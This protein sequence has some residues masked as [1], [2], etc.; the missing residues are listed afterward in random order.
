MPSEYQSG[1][2]TD[3]HCEWCR[4]V[5]EKDTR[6]IK[7]MLRGI[8]TRDELQQWMHAL[9]NQDAATDLKAYATEQA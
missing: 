5:D 1:S 6:T 9:N 3:Y 7:A 2:S 4:H 8:R